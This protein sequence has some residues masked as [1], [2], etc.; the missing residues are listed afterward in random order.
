MLAWRK[1]PQLSPGST[2]HDYD[3]RDPWTQRFISKTD[4]GEL[5]LDVDVR[6]VIRLLDL[7]LYMNENSL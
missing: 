1:G 7:R 5:S 3:E 4:D 2:F 6:R